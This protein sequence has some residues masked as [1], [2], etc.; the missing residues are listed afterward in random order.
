MA[1]AFA[2]Q[3]AHGCLSVF[4]PVF[5]YAGAC[6]LHRVFVLS[7]IFQFGAKRPQ[8]KNCC[9]PSF[10]SFDST[11]LCTFPNLETICCAHSQARAFV[12]ALG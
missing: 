9:L 5:H 7:Q 6:V 1:M 2:G 11:D 8:C 3:R 10:P 12:D 4:S